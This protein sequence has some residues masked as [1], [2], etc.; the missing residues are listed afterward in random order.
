MTIHHL[1]FKLVPWILSA[2]LGTIGCIKLCVIIER[3]K[4]ISKFLN[5]VGN[6]T[7]PILTWHF[8]CFKIMSFFIII[9]HDLPIQ[10]LAEFPVIVEYK[11][12]YLGGYLIVGVFV[13]L[14]INALSC[15]LMGKI[16][17]IIIY[18]RSRG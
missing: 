14:V 1:K 11:D 16:K 6:N 2:L 7:L 5:Y 12:I 8:L 3:F 4:F 15:E 17:K 9:Y 13:P 10:R 18:K